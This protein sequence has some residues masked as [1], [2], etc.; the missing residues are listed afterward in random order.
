MHYSKQLSVGKNFTELVTKNGIIFHQDN[1]IYFFGDQA[2]IFTISL[3]SF[4]KSCVS[5]ELRNYMKD[6]KEIII[7]NGKSIYKDVKNK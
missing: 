5:I 2:I 4:G 3:G 7:K 6:S 1:I